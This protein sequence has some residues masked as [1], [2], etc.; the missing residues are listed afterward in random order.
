MKGAAA[1]GVRICRA[2]ISFWILIAQING[3]VIW[4]SVS[5]QEFRFACTAHAWNTEIIKPRWHSKIRLADD[6]V[7]H[8]SR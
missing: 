1:C 7:P 3:K 5:S 4:R 6:P 2:D 8:N